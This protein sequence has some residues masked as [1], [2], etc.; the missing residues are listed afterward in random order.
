MEILKKRHNKLSHAGLIEVLQDLIV[1][2][3]LQGFYEYTVEVTA[4][5][6]TD[7]P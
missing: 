6:K 3:N 5:K 1:D 4:T 2:E 7:F